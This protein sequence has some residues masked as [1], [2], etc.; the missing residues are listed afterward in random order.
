M[1]ATISPDL[2]NIIVDPLAYQDGD[3]VD[4]AFKAIRRDTPFAKAQASEYDNF[5]VVSRHADVM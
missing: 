2:S 3:A 1:T 4:E 5:W